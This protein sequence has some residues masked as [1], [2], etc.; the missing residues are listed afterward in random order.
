MDGNNV[1]KQGSLAAT[2]NHIS[3]AYLNGNGMESGWAAGDS[4]SDEASYDDDGDTLETDSDKMTTGHVPVLLLPEYARQ[5]NNIGNQSRSNGDEVHVTLTMEYEPELVIRCAAKGNPRPNTTWEYEGGNLPH[6][7]KMTA[8]THSHTDKTN[9]H[10]MIDENGMEEAWTDLKLPKLN[11]AFYG[12][13]RCRAEN[14]RGNATWEVELIHNANSSVFMKLVRGTLASVFFAIGVFLIK[15]VIW[16]ER[17]RQEKLYEKLPPQDLEIINK[18]KKG[19]TAPPPSPSSSIMPPGAMALTPV[20]T[21]CVA[22]EIT[23]TDNDGKCSTKTVSKGYRPMKHELSSPDLQKRG[24]GATTPSSCK[25]VHV[26][27]CINSWTNYVPYDDKLETSSQH[28]K[29]D[30]LKVLENGC[31][32][33]ILAGKVRNDLTM[34]WTN[35]AVKSGKT[36]RDDNFILEAIL[37]ELKILASL[38]KS[39]GNIVNLIGAYTKLLHKRQAYVFVDYCENGNLASF[40]DLNRPNFQD[41]FSGHPGKM[42]ELCG[43]PTPTTNNNLSSASITSKPGSSSNSYPPPV[44]SATFTVG[45][46]K[47][48]QVAINL[49]KPKDIS[50]SLKELLAWSWQ[51]ADGLNFLHKHRILH[52]NLKTSNIY[53]TSKLTLKVGNIGYPSEESLECIDTTTKKFLAVPNFS[54]QHFSKKSDVWNYGGVLWEIFSLRLQP[55]PDE[56]TIRKFMRYEQPQ[57]PQGG[58][59]GIVEGIEMPDHA[60]TEMFEILLLCWNEDFTLC[61]EFDFFSKVFR[62]LYKEMFPSAKTP[63]SSGSTTTNSQQTSDK[64]VV[65]HSSKC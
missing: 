15:A 7:V 42:K 6:Y 45:P 23:V 32:G 37:T 60:S 62:N 39:H 27:D 10:S 29:V 51:I 14:L 47:S 48:S 9:G 44:L 13:L 28:F 20:N 64:N 5:D 22:V 63:S 41:I 50:F 17:R 58:R 30:T 46:A 65:T 36:E 1:D 2:Q 56:Q 52:G 16:M 24:G 11:N 55:C 18:F 54:S 34:E 8:I 21:G 53:V 61:P 31:Y 12:K 59:G 25:S 40:I 38:P 49:E 35:V 4:A 33:M 19:L 3:T 43:E 57:Q 26:V